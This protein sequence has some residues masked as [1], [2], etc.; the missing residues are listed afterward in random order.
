MT[1]TTCSQAFARKWKALFGSALL[2]ITLLSSG[3]DSM[4]HTDQGLLTGAGIGAVFGTMLGLVTRHPVE[5][6]ALGAVA[7]GAVGGV[8]GNAE[9]H[10]EHRA[11]VQQAVAQAA[12]DQQRRW[13]TL[14]DIAK[15]TAEGTPETVI[16]NQIRTTGA[17]YQLSAEDLN[18][19]QQNHVSVAIITEMQAT[20]TRAPTVVQPGVVV[21][22][23]PAVIYGAPPPV[24]VGG[25]YGGYGY[26][27][28]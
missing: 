8:V 23:A 12:A 7:G 21:Q 24:I 1:I 20:A 11:A 22:P 5:G 19:L 3:C 25:Y 28:W 18:Y 9:D 4:S 27:R 15:M 2:S 10:A 14:Y 13:P 6:A 17:I 26:R 16:I